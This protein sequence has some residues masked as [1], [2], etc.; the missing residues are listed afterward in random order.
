M[1]DSDTEKASV[2]ADQIHKT[3]LA[4]GPDMSAR[5]LLMA[6]SMVLARALSILPA[7]AKTTYLE[8]VVS[9]LRA[10]T[11]RGGARAPLFEASAPGR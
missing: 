7:S 10:E 1:A 4:F 9:L 8:W 2:L 5:V 11:A 6:L 3:T